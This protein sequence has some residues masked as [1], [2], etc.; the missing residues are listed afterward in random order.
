M[1]PAGACPPA[2]LAWVRFLLP[3]WAVGQGWPRLV[4]IRRDQP[5]RHHRAIAAHELAHV[6]QW[7]D[8]GAWRFA[9]EYARQWR[10]YGYD[11]M[12]LEGEARAA[13]YDP[14]MLAC[15]AHLLATRPAP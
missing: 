3:P 12:P 7:R 14:A 1:S 10:R 11:A 2:R 13:E 15:A 9:A 6:R 4:L 5:V 8:L